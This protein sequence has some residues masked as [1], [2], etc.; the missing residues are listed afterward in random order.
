MVNSVAVTS[1]PKTAPSPIKVNNN[2]IEAVE[3]YIYLGQR[4]SLLDKGQEK[5]IQRRINAGW[6]AFANHKDI[7][8]SNMPLSLKRKVYNACVLPA[9]TYGSETW[10]LTAAL[11]NKLRVAQRKMERSILGISLIDKKTNKWIRDQTRVKDVIETV[12]R[13]KWRWAGH[14]A[15]MQDNRWTIRITDWTPRYGKRNRGRPA[16]RWRDEIDRFSGHPTW[17]RQAQ[18]R[19]KWK[20]HAEAFVQSVEQE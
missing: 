4:F 18:D 6:A 16:T 20:E 17:K 10:T 11:E 12:K 15:R 14:V 9:I 3:E 8:K 7:F 13:I 5:E 1:L 2:N 19:Q